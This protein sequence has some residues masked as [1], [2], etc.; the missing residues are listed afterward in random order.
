M[1]TLTNG[2]LESLFRFVAE[3]ESLGGD[4]PFTGDLLG[5]LG[6]LVP[7]DVIAYNEL[8]HVRPAEPPTCRLAG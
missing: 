7:A 3:A 8:D 4:Q 1:P 5:E 2:D 6:R